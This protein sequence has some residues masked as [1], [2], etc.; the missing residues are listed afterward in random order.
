M[1]RTCLCDTVWI[2]SFCCK[3]FLNGLLSPPPVQRGRSLVW[4]S[5]I[6][7]CYVTK[8]CVWVHNRSCFSPVAFW[9]NPPV[10]ARWDERSDKLHENQW[11]HKG[12]RLFLCLHHIKACSM[13]LLTGDSVQRRNRNA[14]AKEEVS[15]GGDTS[16]DIRES[17]HGRQDF[18]SSIA[19]G[20]N[21]FPSFSFLLLF[22][23]AI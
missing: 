6:M 3:W 14:L 22:Q 7:R 12:E 9:F 1:L 23:R 18:S 19:Q 11:L 8:T 17:H 20:A 5:G 10:S 4:F 13:D 16:L 15:A 2:I 21:I